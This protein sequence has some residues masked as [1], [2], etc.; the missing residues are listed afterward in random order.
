LE[1]NTRYAFFLGQRTLSGPNFGA[2][3][4]P[5]VTFVGSLL[6]QAAYR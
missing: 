1:G 4:K 6:I 2:S 5:S 3:F